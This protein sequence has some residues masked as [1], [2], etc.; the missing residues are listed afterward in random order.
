MENTKRLPAPKGSRSRFTGWD[1]LITTVLVLVTLVTFFPLIH[2]VAVSLSDKSAVAG[3]M[4]TVYPVGFT[5]AAYQAVIKDGAFFQAFAISVERVI[6]GVSVNMLLTVVTAFAL[7]R[8]R[9]EF[10]ARMAYM[11]TLVFTMMFSGGLIPWYLTIKSL[12]L[13]DNIWA[14][15]LPGAVPVFNVILVMNF[16]KNLPPAIDEAAHMDGAGPWTLLWRI[17]LPMSLPAL[18]TVTLFSV[19]GHWNA[20]FDGLVLMKTQDKYPLQTYLNQIVVQFTMANAHMTREEIERMARLSDKTVSSAKIL[21]SLVPI[22]LVYPFLQRY[23]ISGI[24]LG[25]VKE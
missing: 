18:A 25:S 4:V 24:S 7:S 16:F 10:P 5:L 13:L 9:K 23:F 21:T 19:V 12:C 20:F 14:L 2:I 6:L 15:V 17:Y 22:L 11:W 3:G 8:R 1:V